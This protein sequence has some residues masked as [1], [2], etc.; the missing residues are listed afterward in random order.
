MK[1][2]NVVLWCSLISC[3]LEFV[4]GGD[5]LQ[6]AVFIPVLMMI[7]YVIRNW[8]TNLF[9]CFKLTINFVATRLHDKRE[10]VKG[11]IE[12]HFTVQYL[13]TTVWKDVTRRVQNF[14]TNKFLQSLTFLQF[15]QTLFDSN[16]NVPRKVACR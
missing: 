6:E 5:I 13:G 2:M 7:E 14:G 11:K 16:R 4:W 1:W 9:V 8:M 15:Y 3:W 10:I 12:M